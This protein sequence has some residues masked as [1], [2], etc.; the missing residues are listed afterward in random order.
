M[1]N[2][3]GTGIKTVE[4]ALEI[5]TSKCVDFEQP[6]KGKDG[7]YFVG[8]KITLIEPNS[9]SKRYF[10]NSNFKTLLFLILVINFISATR[11]KTVNGSRQLHQMRLIFEDNMPLRNK[12]QVRR[13]SCICDGCRTGGDCTAEWSVNSWKTERLELKT[14]QDNQE[15]QPFELPD[16]DYVLL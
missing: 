11:H 2:V 13:Y 5:W 7:H 16:D 6:K 8:R 4:E 3:F 9:E 15:N 12:V 14:R 1:D 10:F